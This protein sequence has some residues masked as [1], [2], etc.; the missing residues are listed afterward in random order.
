MEV[1]VCSANNE[2]GFPLMKRSVS[3]RMGSWPATATQRRR[4]PRLNA[5]PQSHCLTRVARMRPWQAS[6]NPLQ[7]PAAAPCHGIRTR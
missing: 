7:S 2:M 5:E 3:A 6:S 4:D 1:S